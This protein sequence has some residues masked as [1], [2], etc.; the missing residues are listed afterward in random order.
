MN[1][2]REAK[3]LSESIK[4]GDADGV[5]RMLDEH[6]ELI[7]VKVQGKF[8]P[9]TNAL[10]FKQ[11]DI[12]RML[13]ERGSDIVASLPPGISGKRRMDRLEA[14]SEFADFFLSKLSSPDITGPNS[15]NRVQNETVAKETSPKERKKPASKE[16]V[17]GENLPIHELAKDG[18][19]SA[20]SKE[21][22]SGTPLSAR[23]EQGKTPAIIAAENGHP[24]IALELLRADPTL[25]NSYGADGITVPML[26]ADSGR[27][28]LIRQT[29][30]FNPDFS[31][32]DSDGKDV[33]LHACAAGQFQTAA[34]LLHM[35]DTPLVVENNGK[36]CLHYAVEAGDE[37][38]CDI[39]LQFGSDPKIKDNSGISPL[40]ISKRSGKRE[41][42]RMFSEHVPLF[43]AAKK[44]SN[45]STPKDSSWIGK[46]KTQQQPKLVV[47]ER[48]EDP[49]PP[50]PRADFSPKQQDIAEVKVSVRK[51]RA[52]A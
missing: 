47:I 5:S 3:L 12:S 11:W 17:L 51:R 49:L 32:T 35:T 13:I 46:K 26:F 45:A 28:D 31:I 25:V 2:Q 50:E 38:F 8:L 36:N 23:N 1:L 24:E 44:Y 18:K 7:A 6:P 42:S 21:V 43:E 15:D 9:L 4:N 41:I 14:P 16:T 52:V 40:D 19:L 10:H 48:R 30:C 29:V 33:V 39:A 37:D 22:A 34:R 27:L 20:I